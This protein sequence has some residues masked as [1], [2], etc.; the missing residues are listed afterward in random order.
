[1]RSIALTG[2]NALGIPARLAKDVLNFIDEKA[3]FFVTREANPNR[4]KLVTP[5]GSYF[6]KKHSVQNIW[7]GNCAGRKV[8]V[9]LK[10]VTG[11]LRFW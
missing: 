1:M 5:K 8:H 2:V 9:S 6:L 4:L 10:K 11:E 7:M 3:Y